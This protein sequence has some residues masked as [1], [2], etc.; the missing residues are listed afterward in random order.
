VRSFRHGS[1]G[2]SRH[3]STRRLP[4]F[5]GG[6]LGTPNLEK[7]ALYGRAR[8]W[9]TLAKYIDHY[10]ETRAEATKDAF[11]C[12]PDRPRLGDRD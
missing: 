11:E 1:S 4:R 3:W 6:P 8:A 5:G 9:E 7:D 2:V 12:C 10:E